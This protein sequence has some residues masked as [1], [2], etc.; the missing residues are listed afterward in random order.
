MKG[1]IVDNIS[2]KPHKRDQQQGSTIGKELTL[3]LNKSD[4]EAMFN[5]FVKMIDASDNTVRTY[6]ISL[7]QWFKYLQEN[8][9]SHPTPD[10]V[11]NYREYLRASGKKETTVQNYIIAVKQFFKWTEMRHIYP[12][13]AQYVKGGKISKNFKKDYLT[14]KQAKKVL[15]SIDRTSIEGKRN[16]AMLAL[17][18]T[19]GLRTIEVV[20]AN[21]EDLRVAGDNTV[22]YVQ[23]KGHHEKDDLVRVPD[24]VEAAIRQYLSARKCKD[25]TQPLFTSTSNRNKN[26]RMTTRSVRGIVK[27]IFR[28]IGLD[29]PRLTA[30]STRHTAA[31]LSLLNGATPIETQH[32]LR[33]KNL[34][35][36]EIYAHNIDQAKNPASQDVEDALF[37]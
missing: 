7:K 25:L 8:N 23:G 16:Y 10:T 29:S 13:I 28:S 22:L 4:L 14:S 11:L 18:L 9:V 26:G 35:T 31:T 34:Q 1:E 6:S 5:D 15:Q 20:R 33:H 3:S 19:T 21:A 37:N 17:M 24:H 30:H 36:T 2:I 27:K 12:N 32:L